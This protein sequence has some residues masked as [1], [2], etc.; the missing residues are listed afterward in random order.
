MSRVY[1]ATR[2]QAKVDT[3]ARVLPG[4]DVSEAPGNVSLD[5]SEDDRTFGT[6]AVAKAESVSAQ[7]PGEIVVATDGGLLVPALG[8]HW[9]PLRTHRFAGIE[10][11]AADRAR[12]LLRLA[13]DLRGL[14]REIG[15]QEA[16]AVAVDGRHLASWLAESPP[17]ELA[18]TL[19]ESLLGADRGFWVP[20]IWRCPECAGKR[21]ADLT[22]DERSTRF[23]H[24]MQLGAAL[25]GWL[26]EHARNVNPTSA[27]GISSRLSL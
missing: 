26:R 9:D 25:S 15:W 16:L 4:H 11:S 2:N 22:D 21:L 23:D 5:S 27:R 10:T 13:G 18:T 17:G 12:S 1:V 14:D 19:H 24:W 7:L 8:D 3:L 6:N 20:A